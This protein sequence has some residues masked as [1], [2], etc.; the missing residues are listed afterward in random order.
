MTSLLHGCSDEIKER[1]KRKAP[2]RSTLVV[3]R[4]SDVT[5]DICVAY[6]YEILVN[7]EKQ[8]AEGRTMIMDG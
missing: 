8:G 1:K 4:S 2:M 3:S 7:K 5:V 6:R